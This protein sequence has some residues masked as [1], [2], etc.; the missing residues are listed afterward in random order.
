M[1]DVKEFEIIQIND[2]LKIPTDK[3]DEFLVGFCEAMKGA[4]AFYDLTT[5][6]AEMQGLKMPDPVLP[7]MVWKDDD[8]KT[9]TFNIHAIKEEKS[10]KCKH[11]T[12][13]GC[14]ARA[15][16]SNKEC[17]SRDE[18]GHPQYAEWPMEKG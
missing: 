13:E 5:L 3:F 11:D 17:D 2:L 6:C 9:T 10:E 16:Y 18:K 4:K 7:R 14:M 1:S 15:C 8:K 12:E